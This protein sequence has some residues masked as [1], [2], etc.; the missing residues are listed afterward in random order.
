LI[1]NELIADPADTYQVRARTTDV[2]KEIDDRYDERTIPH[3]GTV[4]I[5]AAILDQGTL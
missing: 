1:N 2:E 3:K 5:N 4:L